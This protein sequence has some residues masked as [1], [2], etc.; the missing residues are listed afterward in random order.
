M[1]SIVLP[2]K[3][4]LSHFFELIA[5]LESHYISVFEPQHVDF[6]KTFR[7]LP[8]PAQCAYVR[9][10][11]RKGQIF[12]V[13]SVSKYPEIR[14]PRQALVELETYGFISPLNQDDKKSL[15]NFLAKSELSKWLKKS[16]LR[17]AASESRSE[18][19]QKAHENIHV[20]ELTDIESLPEAKL[21]YFFSWEI[22]KLSEEQD[23]AQVLKDVEFSRTLKKVPSQT[24][25]LKDRWLLGVAEKF[26]H[27]NT[28]L[29][30]LAL[31]ECQKHPAREKRARLLYKLVFLSKCFKILGAMKSFYSLKIFLPES[32]IKN[33]SVI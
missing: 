17:V 27:S 3:Y 25:K 31:G 4:Y 9:M 13:A 26:E 6:L 1:S 19:I 12:S 5:H 20:L 11:N 23:E 33:V 14:E 22:E 10:V 7:I 16:G 15:I 8:E 24:L 21:D 2:D 28:E 30:L 29:T 32:L 18:L